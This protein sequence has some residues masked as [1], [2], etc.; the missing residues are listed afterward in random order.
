MSRE[1]LRQKRFLV[2][3]QQCANNRKGEQMKN[4]RNAAMKLIKSIFTRNQKTE[5]KSQRLEVRSQKLRKE[6]DK[7][8]LKHRHPKKIESITAP[9]GFKVSVFEVGV[10]D[11]SDEHA[12]YLQSG[13]T[14]CNI[15]FSE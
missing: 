9:S 15:G 7:K 6:S 1:Q 10:F 3:E 11:D 4:L 13:S 12:C 14:G 5:V 8:T 2:D